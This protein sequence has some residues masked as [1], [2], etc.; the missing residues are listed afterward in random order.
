[1]KIIIE[2]EREEFSEPELRY[3]NGIVKDFKDVFG[4]SAVNKHD[5]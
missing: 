1:M 3:I 4:Q 2:L 5:E